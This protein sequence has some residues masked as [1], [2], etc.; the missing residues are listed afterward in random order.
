MKKKYF[1]FIIFIILCSIKPARSQESY[2]LEPRK[3]LYPDYQEYQ[4]E[5]IKIE[6]P[7]DFINMIYDGLLTLKNGS[8]QHYLYVTNHT[9]RIV[10]IGDGTKDVTLALT[11]LNGNALGNYDIYFLA[12]SVT[13]NNPDDYGPLVASILVH[14]SAHLAGWDE[15]MAYYLQVETLKHLNASPEMIYY[16]ENEFA[17]IIEMKDYW[18]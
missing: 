6:G 9:K 5:K 13:V 11:Y 16:W 7:L 17:P 18:Q 2:D 14:E 12:K 10:F 1:F 4:F 15:P 3:N 8:Y